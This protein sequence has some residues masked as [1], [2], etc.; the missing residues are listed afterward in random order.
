MCNTSVKR[1]RQVLLCCRQTSSLTTSASMTE[2]SAL[3]AFVRTH[4]AGRVGEIKDLISGELSGKATHNITKS[5][6]MSLLAY[7]LGTLVFLAQPIGSRF[8]LLFVAVTTDRAS[9][10]GLRAEPSTLFTAV[11]AVCRCMK[12]HRLDTV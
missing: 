7:E 9:D 2:R 12:A 5:S 10:S 6:G 11:K 1:S 4:Y 8:N 3:G